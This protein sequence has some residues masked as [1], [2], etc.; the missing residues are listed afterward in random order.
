MGTKTVRERG[1]ASR[2]VDGGAHCDSGYRACVVDSHA[3]DSHAWDSDSHA[4]GAGWRVCDEAGCS[5]RDSD[6]DVPALQHPHAT[7]A[8]ATVA[9]T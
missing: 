8:T 1:I 3:W 2:D 4:C 6:S 9:A 7:T 5:L